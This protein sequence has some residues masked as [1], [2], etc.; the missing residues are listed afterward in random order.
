MQ[1]VKSIETIYIFNIYL[2]LLRRHLGVKLHD[3]LQG[4][5]VVQ[6]NIHLIAIE[7]YI[8]ELFEF[9]IHRDHIS[10]GT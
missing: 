10:L 8:E 4:C 7:P 2:F 6:V 1:T 5:S 9:I 3:I